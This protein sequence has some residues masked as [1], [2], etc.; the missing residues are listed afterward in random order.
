M[1]MQP[2]SYPQFPARATTSKLAIWS[3][4]TGILS[5]FCSFLT[6]IPAVIMGIVS[7][8]KIKKSNGTL[9]GGGMAIAGIVTGIICGLIGLAALAALSAPILIRQRHKAEMATLTFHL[10]QFQAHAME[11]ALDHNEAFPDKATAETLLTSYKVSRTAKG[12]WLYFP[13]PSTAGSSEILLISPE[14]PD[15][16]VLHVDGSVEPIKFRADV[17]KLI[18]SSRT[19][20]VEIPATRR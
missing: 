10:R 13:L 7:L 3:L 18:D 5:L 16:V 14:S 15:T 8:N 17:Q 11:Y 9:G 1:E 4:V 19:P 20:P 6:G 2:P 12:D